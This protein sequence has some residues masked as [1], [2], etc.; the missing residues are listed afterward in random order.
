MSTIIVKGE[1]YKPTLA[2]TKDGVTWDLSAATVLILFVSPTGTVIQ[3]TA[4]GTATGAYYT[5]AASDFSGQTPGAGWYWVWDITDGAVKQQSV[6]HKH[7]FT[8]LAAVATS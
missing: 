1:T 4:T 5:I 6:D 7:Y 8:L 2:A 3:K